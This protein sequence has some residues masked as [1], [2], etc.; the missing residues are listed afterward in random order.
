L[1]SRTTKWQIWRINIKIVIVEGD[2]LPALSVFCC[3][4]AHK[5]IDPNF[6]KAM[7]FNGSSTMNYYENSL[8]YEIVVYAFAVPLVIVT[9]LGEFIVTCLLM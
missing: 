4:D 7:A 6:I 5:L 3:V 2:T 8:L 1:D 9:T